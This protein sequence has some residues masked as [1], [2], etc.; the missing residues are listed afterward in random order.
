MLPVAYATPAAVILLIAGLVSCFA[1]YRLF[2]A[3][4]G[5]YGFLLGAAVTSSMMGESNTFALIVAAIVG[6]LVGAVLIVAAY[7]V[8]VGLI[9]AGLAALALHAGWQAVRHVDPPTAIL[10]VVAVLGALLALSVQRYGI[11][12]GTALAGSWTALLGGLRLSHRLPAPLAG[13][14]P[15][16]SNV[17]VIYPL[18]PAST[19]WWFWAAWIGLALVGAVVQLSTSSKLGG[20]KSKSSRKD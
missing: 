3:V 8:G 20:K 4:L 7:F 15:D 9:G 14:T 5:L 10:V 11:V 16:A 18:E 6:G 2:R 12:V 19:Q 13:S 17:W 1:G